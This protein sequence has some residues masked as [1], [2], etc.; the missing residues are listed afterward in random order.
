MSL[1]DNV[2]D[3]HLMILR[4]TASTGCRSSK[5]FRWISGGTAR[6]GTFF[7]NVFQASVKTGMREGRRSLDVG[8]REGQAEIAKRDIPSVYEDMLIV[9]AMVGLTRRRA[10]R[11]Q[12]SRVRRGNLD[13]A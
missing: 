6:K 3:T 8:R 11:R 12:C 1:D 9:L 10:W 2:G 4:H 13:F 5:I 7:E